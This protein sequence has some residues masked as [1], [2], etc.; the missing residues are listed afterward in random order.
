MEPRPDDFEL[1]D[2]L[3]T[4][5]DEIRVRIHL[6]GMEAKEAF[7]AT[8]KEVER[9]IGGPT[10]NVLRKLIERLER[11]RQSIPPGTAH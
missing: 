1:L 10:R 7:A 6:A 3:G 8:E 5:R 11:V 4:L 9:A 2:T